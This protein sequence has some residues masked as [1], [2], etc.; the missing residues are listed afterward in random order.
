MQTR[1]S[2]YNFSIWLDIRI[3]IMPCIRIIHIQIN[4]CHLVSMIRNLNSGF[5]SCGCMIV[6]VTSA[7]VTTG[8]NKRTSIFFL[9]SL[10]RKTWIEGLFRNQ[11]YQI[12]MLLKVLKSAVAA[13]FW[14]AVKMPFAMVWLFGL[15][16]VRQVTVGAMECSC[17]DPG[18]IDA[19]LGWCLKIFEIGNRYLSGSVSALEWI[20]PRHSAALY[21]SLMIFRRNFHFILWPILSA[22]INASVRRI[23]LMHV[24]CAGPALVMLRYDRWL[25]V[26]YFCCTFVIDWMIWLECTFLCLITKSDLHWRKLEYLISLDCHHTTLATR[27]AI[28]LDSMWVCMKCMLWLMHERKK[29]RRA[30]NARRNAA[31]KIKSNG[32]ASNHEIQAPTH[33]LS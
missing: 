13:A 12:S 25:M 9:P 18:L 3:Q 32:N 19:R 10:R 26:K 2:K 17:E 20:L 4:M 15:A 22:T 30:M 27:Y 33:P 11:I 23:E 16:P 6:S 21:R 24:S 7:C 14:Q 29:V 5:D 8:P 31:I 28:N 1:K